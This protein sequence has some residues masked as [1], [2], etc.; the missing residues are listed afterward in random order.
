MSR[1]TFLANMRQ[2]ARRGDG[3]DVDSPHLSSTAGRAYAHRSSSSFPTSSS[4]EAEPSSNGAGVH[5]AEEN[6]DADPGTET[7]AS[8][9]VAAASVNEANHS[10]GGSSG[11]D[12]CQREDAPVSYRAP[13]TEDATECTAVSAS[14]M[15][16]DAAEQPTE[17]STRQQRANGYAKHL[18]SPGRQGEEGEEE[19]A[20]GTG[21]NQQRSNAASL[22]SWESQRHADADPAAHHKPPPP[23]SP[24]YRRNSSNCRG[25][26]GL[27]GHST[28]AAA[29]TATP[30]AVRRGSR[31][32]TTA[33]AAA[34]ASQSRATDSSGSSHHV[35]ASLIALQVELATEKRN[36]IEAEHHIMT[37]NTELN[38][39]R[40]ENARLSREV[41][42]AATASPASAAAK[43]T[44]P[45]LSADAAVA[46]AQIEALE[47]RVGE[48]SRNL[49]A[50]QQELDTK[51]ERIRL[52]EHQLAD[53]LLRQASVYPM[54][55]PAVAE[56]P[57]SSSPPSTPLQRP[58][59]QPHSHVDNSGPPARRLSNAMTSGLPSR[60]LWQADAPDT[61]PAGHRLSSLRHVTVGGSM[62]T[63]DA[64]RTATSIVQR[65]SSVAAHSS[66]LS[67]NPRRPD[68][69]PKTKAATAA[70]EVSAR[71]TRNLPPPPPPPEAE[72][73]AKTAGPACARATP[74]R[75]SSVHRLLSTTR[76]ASVRLGSARRRLS[77][78][79]II[80]APAEAV[81]RVSKT[82]SVRRRADSTSSEPLVTA[83]RRVHGSATSPMRPVPSPA[84]RWSSVNRRKSSLLATTTA[85]PESLQR[86]SA[87]RCSS[88]RGGRAATTRISP[89]PDPLVAGAGHAAHANVSGC[90]RSTSAAS[91]YAMNQRALSNYRS[92]QQPS[93]A[94]SV[95][96]RSARSSTSARPRPQIDFTSDGESSTVKGNTATVTFRT[97]DS[98]VN[99]SAVDNDSNNVSTAADGAAPMRP[100][101]TATT[102]AFASESTAVI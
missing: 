66:R 63:A 4:I 78:S 34:A 81:R 7:N 11:S 79:S 100:A 44:T 96:Q 28:S 55:T 72:P 92:A 16:A 10:N 42:E 49:E 52:L 71:G 5:P 74:Q 58:A 31:P 91:V 84:T 90:D 14:T 21:H 101:P 23:P 45:A 20:D 50:M 29:A 76:P 89:Q 43:S 8:P 22:P 83:V 70:A 94:R 88:R 65:S 1:R 60:R 59:P 24:S 18:L 82:E 41:A 80:P 62:Q 87:Q 51:N 53:Q 46:A 40:L 39:L 102:S 9:D 30:K 12:G 64:A 57:S 3:S 85:K 36:N 35:E 26:A 54:P 13:S 37:L 33:A 27:S 38:T 47:A 73:T 48:L 56:P 17:A 93:A 75:R 67:D 19:E 25:S 6:H 2:E 32:G 15:D 68:P 69:V 95:A 61:A 98:R 77:T 97:R 86:R 99:S